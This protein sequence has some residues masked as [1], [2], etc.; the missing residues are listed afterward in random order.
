VF[1][2]QYGLIPYVKQITF[3][4]WKVNTYKNAMYK[5]LKTNAAIWFN[6]ICKNSQ[7]TPKYVNIKIKGNTR[8][9][10]DM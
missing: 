7:L 10:K 2:V 6:K 9:V 8:W 4:L 5:L 3:S 1:T